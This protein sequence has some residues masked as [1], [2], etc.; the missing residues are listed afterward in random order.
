[1]K[2]LEKINLGW[3]WHHEA[4]SL[5]P[6]ENPNRSTALYQL[7]NQPKIPLSIVIGLV[8]LIVEVAVLCG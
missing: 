7:P 3:A 6:G 2:T 5:K 8:A 1:M 4:P